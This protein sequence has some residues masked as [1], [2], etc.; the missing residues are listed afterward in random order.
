MSRQ[1]IG[2]IAINQSNPD[3]I[4]LGSGEANN[5]RSS[6]WGDGVYKSVDAGENWTNVLYLMEHSTGRSW[7]TPQLRPVR[8]PKLDPQLLNGLLT[9][10][11]LAP[12]HNVGLAYVVNDH[13]IPA[14]TGD[15]DWSKGSGSSKLE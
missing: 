11:T 13:S 9:P 15:V 5:S 1:S 2:S 4:Y 3:I 7:G 8:L 6:Y 10:E 14:F 12:P